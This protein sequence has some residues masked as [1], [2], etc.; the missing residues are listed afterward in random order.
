MCKL[1]KAASFLVW[2]G[3]INWGLVGLFDFNFVEYL[4]GEYWVDRVIYV[5][6][7]ASAIYQAVSWRRVCKA[8]KSK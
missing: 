3:A 2:I 4:V 7:G 8:K 6:V 5:I 1:F